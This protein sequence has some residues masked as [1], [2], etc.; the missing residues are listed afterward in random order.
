MS[1]EWFLCMYPVLGCSLLF[2][3]APTILPRGKRCPL[4]YIVLEF[5]MVLSSLSYSC[6]KMSQAIIVYPE[7]FWW[8]EL[9]LRNVEANLL[10]YA[11]CPISL[12]V[13]SSTGFT[14][15]ML[16]SHAGR[17][18]INIWNEVPI[19]IPILFPFCETLRCLDIYP[20]FKRK[21]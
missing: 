12:L 13:C 6:L 5:G 17:E 9:F 4:V 2:Y 18:W 16:C 11:L 15:H 1:E 19:F 3:N 10:A 20:Y 14:D 8:F 7:M 21:T